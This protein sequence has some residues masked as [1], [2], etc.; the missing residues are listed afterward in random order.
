[1]V[2]LFLDTEFSALRQHAELLSVALVPQ[3]GPW[4]YAVF[5][6]VDLG[7]LSAWHQEHVV[8]HL[9]LTKAQLAALPPGT[10]V[11]GSA[12]EI[13]SALRAYLARFERVEI[14][15]DVPA[16]DWVFFCELF[17]GALRVP[18]HVHY[19]VRDLATL[20]VTKGYD[21]DTD[22]FAFARGNAGEDAGRR[23]QTGDGRTK[24]VAG[25]NGVSAEGLERHSALGDAM[26]ARRCFKRLN[27]PDGQQ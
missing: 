26:V 23:I 14:W 18:K 21:V 1:M 24:G 25:G 3:E 5:T 11:R 8:P 4:F 17:G 9:P 15:A 7:S 10:Y 2:R 22:R 16:Y 6:E 12:D 19:I 20:F 13:V 27:Q